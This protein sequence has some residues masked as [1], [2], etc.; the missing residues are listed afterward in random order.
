A[1]ATKE[2]REKLMSLGYLAG[3]ALPPEP[4][5]SLPN[6]RDKIASYARPRAAF[7]LVAQRKEKEAVAAFDASLKE[8]P[9]FVDALTERAAALGR[10]GRYRDSARAYETAIARAP[11]LAARV[12]LTLARVELEM[13]DFAK[14]SASAKKALAAEPATAHEL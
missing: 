9:A 11:D 13:G 14:A 8:N 1:P 6:P 3:G 10:L 2:E 7:A 5:S 12:S 4:G